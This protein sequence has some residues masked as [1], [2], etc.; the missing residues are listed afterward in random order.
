MVK[1]LIYELF[2]GVGFCNQLFSLETAIYLAN[3]SRRKLILLVRNPLCHCGN[4]RWEYGKLLEMFSDDY[5][6]YLHNGIEVHYGAISPESE[7]MNII[8][9]VNKTKKFTY[10]TRFSSLVFVDS[11][12]DNEKNQEDIIN[13]LNGRQKE[14]LDF[15]KFENYDYFYINQSNAS[16][17]FYNFYTTVENYI[18]MNMQ[19][20]I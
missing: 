11:N 9:N 6:Q 2:S 5:L 10:K 18:L 16:R 4:A 13:Y 7:I 19:N 17:C 12:L 3:I 15:D 20:S 8:E 14:N 1:H